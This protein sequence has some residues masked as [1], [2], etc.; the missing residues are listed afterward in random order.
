MV[1]VELIHVREALINKKEKKGAITM[2][3]VVVASKARH[4]VILLLSFQIAM[5]KRTI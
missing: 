4:P 1:E 3:V 5:R 2:E